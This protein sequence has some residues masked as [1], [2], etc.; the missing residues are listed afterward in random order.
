MSRAI[1]GCPLRHKEIGLGPAVTV[2]TGV[3]ACDYTLEAYVFI[4]L[5]ILYV[6]YQ[7]RERV[8]Y[9]DIQIPRSGLKNEAQPSF[10]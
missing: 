2:A 8:F 3:P 1:T 5:L 4:V 10:F 6:I 9:Q 7:T